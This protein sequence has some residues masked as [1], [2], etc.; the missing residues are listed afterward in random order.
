[1]AKFILRGELGL[2]C[3][4][5]PGKYLS[6]HGCLSSK[7]M[8]GAWEGEGDPWG[9]RERGRKERCRERMMESWQRDFRERV[10]L[11][12]TVTTA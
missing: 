2:S 7:E 5:T 4:V 6:L 3:P 10:T 11:R 1:M 8:K 12:D 9:G